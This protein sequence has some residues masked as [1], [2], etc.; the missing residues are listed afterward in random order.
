MLDYKLD[1][2]AMKI[3]FTVDQNF[4]KE[5][6]LFLKN[7]ACELDGNLIS[8]L[9]AI[10]IKIKIEDGFEANIIDDLNVGKAES[11]VEFCLG[12]NS[13]LF[14]KVFFAN[15][16]ICSECERQ[17]LS[18]CQELT[19]KKNHKEICVFLN[20]HGA[21]ANLRCH[22]LSDS[23]DFKILTLQHHMADATSS[24]FV[25][26]SVLDHNST[27]SLNSMIQVGKN[28]VGIKA[29]FDA[30]SLI[31]DEN[32]R[33]TCKPQVKIYSPG[34]R[35]THGATVS[36]LRKQDLFYLRSRGISKIEAE[37]SLIDAFLAMK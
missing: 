12:K 23:G 15:H 29:K 27:L 32:S 37:K 2:N 1:G 18:H 33:A 34:S 28:L 14:Y 22:N 26:N 17:D 24:E 6:P 30:R 31:L 35:C 21:E 16:W 11:K 20:G 13:R 19:S 8:E 5:D 7:L 3:H 4:S 9:E 36:N 25:I 10:N